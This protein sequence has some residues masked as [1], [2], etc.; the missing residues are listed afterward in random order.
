MSRR[1]VR[2]A[3]N[4]L[5]WHPERE[6][7]LGRVYCHDRES[8]EGFVVIQGDEVEE[9]GS[10]SFSVR[11]TTIPHYKVFRITYGQEVLFER[12]SGAGS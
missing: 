5:L 9:V 4:E 7:S 8:P 2:E 1:G 6:A 11:G 12:K 3:L 10:S